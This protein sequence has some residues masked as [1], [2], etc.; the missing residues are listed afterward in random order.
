MYN[1]FENNTNDVAI[2]AGTGTGNLRIYL[3]CDPGMIDFCLYFKIIL[4]KVHVRQLW[5]TAPAAFLA[6]AVLHAQ[7]DNF[8][9][10]TSPLT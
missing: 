6:K 7:Y 10:F 3:D 5:G 4:A 1:I 8:C 2:V 9:T